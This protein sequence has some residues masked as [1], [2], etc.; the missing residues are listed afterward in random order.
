VPRAV[1]LTDDLPKP[2]LPEGVRVLNR[3]GLLTA[4]G[5]AKLVYKM[6]GT[7]SVLLDGQDVSHRA[8]AAHDIDG[9]VEM[10]GEVDGH[11]FPPAVR[12]AGRV[13]FVF[14]K[15]KPGFGSLSRTPS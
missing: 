13:E 5:H 7:I 10:Y 12:H 9:W 3:V 6:G 4:Q 14:R 2:A 15:E 8:A 1:S 11:L